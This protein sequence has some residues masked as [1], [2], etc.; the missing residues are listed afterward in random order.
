MKK[1]MAALCALAF[2]T[3]GAQAQTVKDS[4]YIDTSVTAGAVFCFAGESATASRQVLLDNALC[5]RD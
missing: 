4:T 1:L 2:F 3:T 5:F